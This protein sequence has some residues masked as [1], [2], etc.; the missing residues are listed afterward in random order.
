[1]LFRIMQVNAKDSTKEIQMGIMVE[2]LG[3]TIFEIN[4]IKLFDNML[5]FFN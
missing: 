3:T 4:Y 1:M 5:K 2:G